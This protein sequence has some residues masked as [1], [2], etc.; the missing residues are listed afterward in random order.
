MLPKFM[1]Y[2]NLRFLSVVFLLLVSLIIYVNG[3][4][5]HRHKK[6]HESTERVVV[7][8]EMIMMLEVVVYGF[9]CLLQGEF[10]EKHGNTGYF[11]IAIQVTFLLILIPLI[12]P[13]IMQLQYAT[14][15]YHFIY[16]NIYLYIHVLKYQFISKTIQRNTINY[17]QVIMSKHNNILLTFF[18]FLF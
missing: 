17:F 18:F 16:I 3:S 5:L 11:F 9:L 8:M 1:I 2:I 6:R 7:M 12:P 15:V 14:I 13:P 4:E 10:K